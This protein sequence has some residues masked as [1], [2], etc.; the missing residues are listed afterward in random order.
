MSGTQRRHVR[1][2]T[3]PALATCAALAAV[4]LLA[5]GAGAQTEPSEG[6]TSLRVEIT[7]LDGLVTDE[8]DLHIRAQVVNEGRSDRQD[9]R[10]LATVHRQPIGRFN[11][12]Q[13]MDNGVVGDV[14]HAFGADIEDV[15]ARGT[16]TVEL[17]QT[18]AELGLGRPGGQGGVYPLRIQ[19][20][21]G[22]Q[23]VDEVATN[24]VYAPDTVDL[25]IAVSLLLPI[26]HSPSRDGHGVFVSDRLLRATEPDGA[27]GGLAAVLED[28]PDLPIT[29]AVDALTLEEVG[30]LASGF[31]REQGDGAEAL[32]SDSPE[33]ERAAALGAPAPPPRAPPAAPPR[34]P[35]PRAPPGRARPPNTSENTRLD[36]AA[37][38]PG[39]PAAGP[40]GGPAPR[41]IDGQ[42]KFKRRVE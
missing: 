34:R 21:S 28:R 22:G 8:A 23:V 32:P 13:A 38:A 20:Q 30:D 37:P 18:A 15:P 7:R 11:Y 12:Q 26:A 39:P 14:I 4:A 40:G 5:G 36:V 25:P 3:A 2:A 29:L 17:G 10:L 35:A 16:R 6:G 19:L 27:L 33:A 9:L 41:E 1:W 24:L 31:M 42:E